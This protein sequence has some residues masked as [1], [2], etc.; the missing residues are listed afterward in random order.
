MATGTM[1]LFKTWSEWAYAAKTGF[2]ILVAVVRRES[3]DAVHDFRMLRGHVD[4]YIMDSEKAV[5]IGEAD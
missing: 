4:R 2:D 1:V 5:K 3:K